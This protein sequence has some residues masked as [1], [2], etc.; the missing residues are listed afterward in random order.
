V[1]GLGDGWAGLGDGAGEV[2]GWEG[3]GEVPGWPPLPGW[4]CQYLRG[5]VPARG[6]GVVL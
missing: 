1:P 3:L 4:H 5:A 2:V 6:I